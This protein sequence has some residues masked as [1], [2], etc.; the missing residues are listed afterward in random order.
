MLSLTGKV[1]HS[2]QDCAVCPPNWENGEGP[3][4]VPSAPSGPTTPLPAHFGLSKDPETIAFDRDR[5]LMGGSPLRLLRLSERAISLARGWQSGATVG[6]RKAEQIL[7][8]RLVSSGVF[9]P[10]PGPTPFGPDDV[11]VVIPVRD[12]PIA[13]ER[14]LGALK[15]VPRR[16]RCL[17]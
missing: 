8:R 2:C 13:L 6:P 17:G 5:V 16:R 4:P 9:L 15:G 12:R 3:T 14:V 1:P 7:A 11:T 10:R